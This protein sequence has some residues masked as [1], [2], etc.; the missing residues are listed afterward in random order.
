MISS[1]K[2]ATL[3]CLGRSVHREEDHDIDKLALWL[4]GYPRIT[5]LHYSEANGS[6]WLGLQAQLLKTVNVGSTPAPPDDNG[7]PFD[8]TFMPRKS[9]FTSDVD[10]HDITVGRDDKPYFIATQCNCLC[11]V[12]EDSDSFKVVWKPPWISRLTFE[13]RCH[14]N[15]LCSRDGVP[16][17]VTS[18]SRSDIIGGWREH[19]T[20]GGIVYD[21]VEDRLV[22]E[23]LSMPH[24]PRW[25]MNR[26]WVLEAGA[27]QF[28]YVNEEGEFEAKTFVPGFLRGL[29]FVSDKYAVVCC[30]I[31]RHEKLFQGLPLGER[32]RREGLGTRCG[33]Y[34]IDLATFNIVHQ[35]TFAGEKGPIELFDVVVIPD[36]QRPHAMGINDPKIMTHRKSGGAPLPLSPLLRE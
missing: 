11:T 19:R 20:N 15:G 8:T 29:G 17:Y 4:T 21:I 25:H 27:G 36:S 2:S 34:V 28:G 14:L 9:Y 6:L 12:S 3:F 7:S 5:G 33:I 35:F 13:D 16:R 30:S 10:I 18:V 23:G 22:C 32:L 1:Y 26:L 24:S 31:D